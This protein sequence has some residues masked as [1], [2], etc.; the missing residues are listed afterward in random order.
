M[1]HP[2]VHVLAGLS[3]L[4]GPGF[5]VWVGVA[6]VWPDRHDTVFVLV[7]LAMAAVFFWHGFGWMIHHLR[8]ARSAARSGREG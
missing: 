5:M 7:F 4:F 6:Y 8:Q 1:N 2:V 3:F